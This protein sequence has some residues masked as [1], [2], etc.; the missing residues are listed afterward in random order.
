MHAIVW[1]NYIVLKFG[2][3]WISSLEMNLAMSPNVEKIKHVFPKISKLKNM[4]G[5]ICYSCYTE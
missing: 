1:F 2:K 3:L 4:F 5:N